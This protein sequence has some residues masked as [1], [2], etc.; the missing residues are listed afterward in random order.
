MRGANAEEFPR[1]RDDGV[2]GRG[3][4]IQRRDGGWDGA[5]SLEEVAG[6]WT[7]SG[8]GGQIGGVLKPR[9]SPSPKDNSDSK[10]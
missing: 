8:N 6:S 5:P 4:C 3:L 7:Q 10:G 1:G 9:L 2:S